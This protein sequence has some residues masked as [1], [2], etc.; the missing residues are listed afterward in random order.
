[1][2]HLPLI[3]WIISGEMTESHV[4]AVH[5][6]VIKKMLAC[7]EDL[8]CLMFTRSMASLQFLH[9]ILISDPPESSFLSSPCFFPTSHPILT[10]NEDMGQPLDKPQ[11][12]RS[13]R[14]LTLVSP[15]SMLTTLAS[16]LWWKG[17]ASKQPKPSWKTTIFPRNQ[18]METN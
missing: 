10:L 17:P 5:T 16:R 12:T 8:T 2:L 15:L 6:F 9:Y 7:M 18:S 4:V 3:F 11:T 14:P 1:M 13:I